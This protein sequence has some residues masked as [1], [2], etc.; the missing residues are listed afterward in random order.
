VS[1]TGIGISAEDQTT[2]FNAFNQADTSITRR[3]GGSGLGLVICKT[4]AEH[5][6]GRISLNSEI[7]KGSR[8]TIHIK[9][10]KL[11]S[12]EVE[13]HQIHRFSDLNVLCFDDNP[14]HLEALCNGLGFW[15]INCVRIDAFNK[16]EEAFRTY[17]HCHLA[18]V[19]VNQGCEQQVAQVLYKR[20]MP[21]VLVSKWPIQDHETL[22]AQGFLFKP[23]NMQ[24]L[25]DTVESLLNK[26][27]L[28]TTYNHELDTLREQL[29]SARPLLLVAED[30][31]VNRMLLNSMLGENA[32]ITTVDDG[33]QAVTMCNN[34]RFN[35]IL[36]DLQMPILNGIEAACLIHQ[37]SVL[38]KNTPIILISANS[39][40][41]NK[42]HLANAGIEFCLQKP[43]DEESLLRHLLSIISKSKPAAINWPLCVQKVSGNQALATEFL[44][45]FVVELQKN[46]EEFLQLMHVHNVKGLERAAHKLHGACCFC[47]VPILQTHVA[48]L[49][50]LARNAKHI[51]ELQRAFAELI[52]SIDAV[53]GEYGTSYRTYQET[54]CQ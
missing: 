21:C 49:E 47:G 18:F 44:A 41:L 11:A 24:K 30:N 38:N 5:M 9:L 20:S 7:Y 39:C 26:V 10:E 50:N 3:Y 22:G 17:S 28:T 6:R 35:A 8:F 32:C 25:H 40:D 31:P 2:L 45:R 15:G 46:R 16:L 23:P 19:S 4:L 53:L 36:L 33:K 37:E 12:Y 34:K 13:K 1:D 54:L 48:H 14:L 43:I 29:R 52:L 27:A 42:E 51:D